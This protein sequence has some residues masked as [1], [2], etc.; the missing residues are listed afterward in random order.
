MKER[1]QLDYFCRSK[2]M[3]E[4]L[5]QEIEEKKVVISLYSDTSLANGAKK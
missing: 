2:L 1:K 5:R 3:E 4:Y